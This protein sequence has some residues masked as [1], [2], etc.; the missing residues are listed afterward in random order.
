[1]EGGNR[2]AEG[3]KV[4]D[5]QSSIKDWETKQVDLERMSAPSLLICFSIFYLFFSKEG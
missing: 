4:E 3:V 2:G 1:M 5:R